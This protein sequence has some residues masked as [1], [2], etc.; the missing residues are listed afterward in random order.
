MKQPS[1]GS[2]GTGRAEHEHHVWHRRE[3]RTL[4]ESLSLLITVS[5]R[6]WIYNKDKKL[7]KATLKTRAKF[8]NSPSV[9][10]YASFERFCNLLAL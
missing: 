5:V 2:R 8:T 10:K 3:G 1:E 6:R 9:L 7:Y 4:P